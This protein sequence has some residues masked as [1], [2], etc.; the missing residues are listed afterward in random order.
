MIIKGIQKLTLID[1]P[2]KMAATLFF[3]GCSFRCPFCHNASLVVG[4][5]NADNF[6]DIEADE[7]IKFLKSRRG[8]LD[9]VVL[10][11]GEPLLRDGIEDFILEIKKSGFA[12]KLDTNGQDFDKLKLL[13]DNKII[14]Y[15][16]MDIKNS[17]ENYGE[18][19]GIPDLDTQNIEKSADFLIGGGFPCEF[20][21][22]VVK[23]F[24]AA[25]DFHSI[26]KRFAGANGITNNNVQK[27]FLQTFKDSGDTIKKGLSAYGKEEMAGFRD[28][29][30]LYIPNVSLREIM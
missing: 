26:G 1:Y 14:D 18:T 25:E 29:L 20:R 10:S 4:A 23:E 13:I 3:G 11:G 28:I 30:S 16:A 5:A 27:Y 2:G 12:V 22:T 15:V 19:V 8:V 24:H 9:G 6:N 21:T 17:L 7:A